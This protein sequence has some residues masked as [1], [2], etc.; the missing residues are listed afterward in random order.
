MSNEAV[1]IENSFL[2]RAIKNEDI[3]QVQ[4]LISNN[5]NVNLQNETHSLLTLAL[6]CRQFA[7]ADMLIEAG[8]QKDYY[9]DL[10]MPL[11]AIVAQTINS[12]EEAYMFRSW[13]E[14]HDFDL[15]ETYEYYG[16]NY[17]FKNI[18]QENLEK[19]NKLKIK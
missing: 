7:I 19:R 14:S 8:A 16:L 6:L 17:N 15:N 3:E 1:N 12:H 2:G 10:D 13:F 4:K 5:H 18:I 9:N 11:T